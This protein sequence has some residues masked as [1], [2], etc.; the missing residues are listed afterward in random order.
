MGWKLSSNVVW[1]DSR[2]GREIYQDGKK[3]LAEPR[4]L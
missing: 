3:N 2:G 1:T 4:R